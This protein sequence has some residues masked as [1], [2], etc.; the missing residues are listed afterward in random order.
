MH[1]F[2]SSLLTPK[3]HGSIIKKKAEVSKNAK[4]FQR[5]KNNGTERTET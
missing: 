1:N 2:D 3:E 4:T 5:K